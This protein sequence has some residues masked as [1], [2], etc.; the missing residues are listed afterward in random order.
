[1]ALPEGLRQ[2][3]P[4]Q[5]A[6]AFGRR[7]ARLD[8]VALLALRSELPPVVGS[9]D[10]GQIARAV[11]RAT[12]GL[13]APS[14]QEL[15]AVGNAVNRAHR[16][17][18]FRGVARETRLTIVNTDEPGRL[19]TTPATGNVAM[20]RPNLNPSLAVRE[21]ASSAA[22]R[23]RVLREGVQEATTAAVIR[24]VL[25]ADGDPE[26]LTQD[27]LR[28]W[29]ANGVPS[30]IPTRR[31]TAAGMPVAVNVRDH[32]AFIA[33]DQIGTLAMEITRDRQTAAGI[34]KFVWLTK[35]DSRVRDSHRSRHGKTFAWADGADGEF[36]GG[37]P[38]CRC[39]AAAV[40]ETPLREALLVAQ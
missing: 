18:F 12:E 22:A 38:N 26:R 35:R 11:E 40:I 36:P 24:E 8:R 15:M 6:E 16:T 33:R 3:F 28:L 31:R 34:R 23:V 20:V 13:R 30:R 32:A 14:E 21:F 4:S 39:H 1:M 9:Q 17:R 10:G 5:Q 7:L 25:Q 29:E 2:P 37:P 19:L 27:L